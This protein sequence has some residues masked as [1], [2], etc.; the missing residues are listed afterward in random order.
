MTR[1][2]DILIIEDDAIM[3]EALAEWLEAAGY[4]VRK[5][6]TGVPD[7]PQ[8]KSRHLRWWL[9]TSTCPE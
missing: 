6:R 3:R 4:G 1:T 5:V 7:W 8:R 2:T 9:P